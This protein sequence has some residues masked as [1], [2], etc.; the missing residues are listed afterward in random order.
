ME[1]SL[2]ISNYTRIKVHV[3]PRL[4]LSGFEQ[5]INTF[6]NYRL[7]I[8]SLVFKKLL[9]IITRAVIVQR[10]IHTYI[11]IHLHTP[12]TFKHL[13]S[14]SYIFLHKHSPSYTFI[15]LHTLSFTITHL[16]T[17]SCTVICNNFNFLKI[18][19]NVK[20]SCCYCRSDLYLMQRLV[21]YGPSLSCYQLLVI[22]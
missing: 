18:E 3:N 16:H 2:L 5:R 4:A 21:K 7:L 20:Q 8:T 1:K 11:F 12:F 15:D 9:I 14:S 10:Y 13:Y 17:P 19:G 22:D 6:Y